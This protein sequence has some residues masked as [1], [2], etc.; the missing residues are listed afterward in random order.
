MNKSRTTGANVHKTEG[1]VYANKALTL[2][3]G[4]YPRPFERGLIAWLVGSPKRPKLVTTSGNSVAIPT[5]FG[6][7]STGGIAMAREQIRAPWHRL[8]SDRQGAVL[9]ETA[10]VMPVLILLA[11]GS[12]DVGRMVSLELARRLL[13][14][15]PD[16]ANDDIA[17]P[18]DYRPPCPCC[19]G[20]MVITEAFERWRQPR[21]PPAMTSMIRKVTS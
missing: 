16:P 20:R 12:F 10:I 11:L 9:I 13:A 1:Y 21:A 4:F 17:E 7:D 8:T 15:A 3:L 19:G 18:D 2:A 14:V 5:R 6:Y